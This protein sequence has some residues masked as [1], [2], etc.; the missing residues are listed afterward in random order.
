MKTKFLRFNKQLP[1]IDT[2]QPTNSRPSESAS[3]FQTSPYRR[4]QAPKLEMND[5]TQAIMKLSHNSSP[6]YQLQPRDR[7][8][9]VSLPEIDDSK[10]IPMQELKAWIS[11]VCTKVVSSAFNLLI[12]DKLSY[13]QAKVFCSESILR[14][15]VFLVEKYPYKLTNH[16]IE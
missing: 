7:S 16:H 4:T 2:I 1:R 8:V 12:S 6:S 11:Q 14:N 3:P 13:E 10:D 9:E 15:I 5:L